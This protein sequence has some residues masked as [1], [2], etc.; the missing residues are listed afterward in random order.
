MKYRLVR[1]AK[2]WAVQKNEFVFHDPQACPV[3]SRTRLIWDTIATHKF[4]WV[5]SLKLW[6]LRERARK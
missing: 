6:W 2:G 4:H 5:A 1:R 3:S